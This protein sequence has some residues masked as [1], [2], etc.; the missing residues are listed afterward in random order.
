MISANND[1]EGNNV[2]A[3]F[4]PNS[5]ETAGKQPHFTGRAII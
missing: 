1:A 2:V 3:L 5:P 4:G